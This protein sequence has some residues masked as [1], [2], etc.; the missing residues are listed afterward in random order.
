[1]DTEFDLE[2]AG[3]TQGSTFEEVY[4]GDPASRV[5]IA[6]RHFAV[7]VD[8]A[9]LVVGHL[10]VIPRRKVLSFASLDDDGWTEWLEIRGIVLPVIEAIYGVPAVVMEHGSDPNLEAN[11][12]I[13]HAHMHVLPLPSHV[14]L[15]FD[16]DGFVTRLVDPARLRE[17]GVA[18]QAY[19]YAERVGQRATLAEVVVESR[20]PIQYLRRVVAR[21]IGDAAIYDWGVFVERE[22]L[23]RT[24][25]DLAY[26]VD[27]R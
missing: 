16:R 25:R 19:F 23:R 17:V 5:V 8:I 12:C 3:E 18:A 7:L 20:P 22:R 15:D 1:M 21:A 10:L 9:P 26:L 6:W 24:V 13:L 14:S 4:G 27:V 11:A 2:L